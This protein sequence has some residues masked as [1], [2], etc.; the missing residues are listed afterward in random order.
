VTTNL[1]T[2]ESKRIVS[3]IPTDPGAGRGESRDP[4]ETGAVVYMGPARCCADSGM[5]S[6]YTLKPSISSHSAP[7]WLL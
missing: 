6:R 7:Y 1:G 4:G 3:V 5:T 2:A